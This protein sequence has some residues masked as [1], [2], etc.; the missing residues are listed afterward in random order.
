MALW[1]A[2]KNLH[3]LWVELCVGTA[4]NLLACVRHRKSIV[5]GPVVKHCIESIGDEDDACPERNLFIAQVDSR[6][7]EELMVGGD[8]VGGFTQEANNGWPLA[9]AL[10]SKELEC[11]VG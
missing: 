3:N 1:S 9:R 7:I 10:S 6:T 11:V 5:I 2:E 4:A 8:D